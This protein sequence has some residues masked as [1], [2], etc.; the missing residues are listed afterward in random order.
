MT[1][2]YNSR[3]Q[4]KTMFLQSLKPASLMAVLAFFCFAFFTFSTSVMF[5]ISPEAHANEA[6]TISGFFWDELREDGM[7]SF[8]PNVCFIFAGVVNAILLFNCVWSKKQVNVVFSLGMKRTD[9]YISKILGG[10]LP[11]FC[12]ILLAG[13]LET[14]ACA[15]AGFTVNGRYIA[16]AV[17]CVLQFFAVYA[18]SFLL[19]SAVMSNSGNVI[20]SLIFTALIAISISIVA[21]FIKYMFWEFTLGASL[22]ANSSGNPA[23]MLENTDWNWSNPFLGY[24]NLITY[25]K[26]TYFHKYST[27]L[28]NIYDWSGVI[29][30]SVYSVIAFLLGLFGF[31]RRRNEISGTWGRAKA[32]NEIAAALAGFYGL[33]LSFAVSLAWH[34]DGDAFSY[35]A[36]CASFLICYIVTK[37]IFGYKRKKEIKTAFN[38]FPAYA[39]VFAAICLVFSLGLFG[40]S[41]ELPDLSEIKSV[42]VSSPTYKLMDDNYSDSSYFG[43]KAQNLNCNS[44]Y[45]PTLQFGG[46][47]YDD[48]YTSAH[49]TFT[50][51][52]DVEKVLKIHKAFIDDGKIKNSGAHSCATS[53]TI[54]YTLKNG[55]VVTRYY[56][57]TTEGTAQKLLEL[58]ETAGYENALEK[59]FRPEDDS[60]NELETYK[61][62]NGH[63][64]EFWKNTFIL[65]LDCYLF[66]KDMTKGYNIGLIDEKLYDA[67]A[68]DIKAM[69]SKQYYQHTG[70][71]EIGILS[72]GL[73]NSDFSYYSY[74]YDSGVVIDT[75]STENVV[76]AISE[77]AQ[78]IIDG[79]YDGKYA[80]D[81]PYSDKNVGTY[82][83][84]SW[85]LNSN[86]VKAIVLTTDMKN[87]VKYLEEHDLMK[88]FE[89]TRS[90]SDIK[91]VKLATPGELYD[92]KNK[93][94]NYPV[95]Y[96]AY[97]IGD[98][99][100]EF[101]KSSEAQYYKN[102]FA[103]I[104]N[105]ITDKHQISLL[106]KDATL[107]G[108]CSND[109]RIMEITY[110]DGSIETVMV[111]ANSEGLR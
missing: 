100:E 95:F 57:E 22:F 40:Y 44:Q 45:N 26:F 91:S 39:I 41:S 11:M 56:T 65:N 76:T 71:S 82:G 101:I 103:E 104:D 55:K 31:K 83:E 64:S 74:S 108:L 25:F 42:E 69:S 110:K 5:I 58:N 96:S 89:S 67:I 43:L 73:S 9:I 50:E 48:H 14:A 13:T 72:F 17:L 6:E 23:E 52:S 34:G 98:Q 81:E 61:Y 7:F 88:Y 24:W 16:L 80:E 15:A 8:M 21:S 47:I 62:Y 102:H 59:Y 84:T 77:E 87:T 32:L 20:E 54:T 92:K 28:P 38:R 18:L 4:F 12:A 3:K 70:E 79:Y 1:S 60:Q 19:S 86:D 63:T 30:A 53:V 68:K 90:A 66:P 97:L 27:Q 33:Y 35:L 106:L 111:P 29:S 46:Y 37:L 93:S 85:N 51:K 49:I 105:Q 78:T 99:I 107:F 94:Y 10:L 36:G 109:T 2:T 75:E